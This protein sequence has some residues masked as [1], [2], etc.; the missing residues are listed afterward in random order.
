MKI[1]W[2]ILLISAFTDFIIVAVPTVISAMVSTG[3]V[4]MPSKAT[5]LL[6]CLFGLVALARTVQGA[7]K[8]TPETSAALKGS[9]SIV[10]TSTIEKTP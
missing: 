7:L 5:V 9:V 10:S 2:V 3:T 1:A 6:A 4:S 8:A